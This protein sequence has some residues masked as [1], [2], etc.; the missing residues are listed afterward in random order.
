MLKPAQLYKEQLNKKY[1]ETWY[2]KKYMYYQS[3]PVCYEI[4][5]P[6][7]N[8]CGYNFVYV[9]EN[10][11]ITGYFS[12]K[13]NWISKNICNF[14]LISFKDN[15]VAFI[16]DVIKHIRHMLDDV[17]IQRIEFWA[18]KE[19]PANRAY[20]KLVKKFGGAKVATLHNVNMLSDGRLH[21]MVIYEILRENYLEVIK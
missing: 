17:G 10:D 13:I 21:D 6:D 12:Y 19:N 2:D 18:Y 15:N 7:N 11:D 5:I 14:G 8:E 3:S 1:I 16:R 9:D 4:Q 20:Q